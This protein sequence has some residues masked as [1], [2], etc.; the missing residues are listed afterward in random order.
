[1]GTAK[2]Y[3]TVYISE[4]AKKLL[5]DIVYTKRVGGDIDYS[6]GD[7]F[8]EGL[9]LLKKSLPAFKENPKK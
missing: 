9:L 3:V 4:E 6:N 2:K 8:Y 5:D 7:A 1:M